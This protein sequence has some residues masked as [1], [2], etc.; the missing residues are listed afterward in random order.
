MKAVMLSPD[1]HYNMFCLYFIPLLLLCISCVAWRVTLWLVVIIIW[2]HNNNFSG[3]EH[4]YSQH[5]NI[6]DHVSTEHNTIN[7]KGLFDISMQKCYMLYIYTYI[8]KASLLFIT[9]YNPRHW[10]K[11]CVY[12]FDM[13]VVTIIHYWNIIP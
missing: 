7:N 9:H 1:E 11:W 3:S 8:I 13:T 12:C 5:W 10:P 2:Y 6:W 4:C